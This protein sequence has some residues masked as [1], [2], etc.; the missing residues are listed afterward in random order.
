MADETRPCPQ[1][2]ETIQSQA[3]LCRF[4]KTRFDAPAAAPA[5]PAAAAAANKSSMLT[6]LIIGIC[7]GVGGLFVVGIVAALLIPAI[8][9]ATER[10]KVTA[11][12]SNLRQLWSMQSVYASQFGGREM[13]LPSETGAA[14]WLKLTQT[15]PPLIDSTSTDIFQCPV[16]G[17]EGERPC[18]YLGPARNANELKA[19]D[20]VGAD[21]PGNHKK[22]GNVQYKNGSVVEV[23]DSEFKTVSDSLRP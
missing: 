8:A 11:C 21:H 6:C 1:C 17:K 16:H 10:A 3:I 13:L 18:D 7:V 22:G 23:L 4:C 5:T 20:P 14:F 15:Q 2:G 9:K 12:A 19:E